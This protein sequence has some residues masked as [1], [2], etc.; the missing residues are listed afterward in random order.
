MIRLRKD[1]R[2]FII[3]IVFI[4]SIYFGYK[5][6]NIIHLFL[7]QQNKIDTKEANKIFEAASNQRKVTLEYIE[8]AQTRSMINELIFQDDISTKYSDSKKNYQIYIIEIPHE[9]LKTEINKLRQLQ[10]L[11]A[12][13]IKTDSEMKLDTNVKEN[14]EN[15][16]ITKKRLQELIAKTSSPQSL[17]KFQSD[18]ERTQVKIDSLN[19]FVSRQEHLMNYDLMYIKSI[20]SSGA[21]LSAR[22]VIWNFVKRTF[23][24]MLFLVACLI[25][26][27]YI[28]VLFT[29]LMNVMGIKSSRGGRGSSNYNYNY[30]KRS[31]GRKVKRIYKNA[32]G[33]RVEKKDKE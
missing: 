3:F 28:M 11:V 10:G 22:M 7:P 13:H 5:S 17:D 29:Y 24:S 23:G 31:Y 20:N 18:L 15:H 4:I 21:G 14:L 8:A 12:E 9:K 32:D 1:T 19:N 27:Y 26:F 30:N 33:T 2:F 16:K 25:A 6:S